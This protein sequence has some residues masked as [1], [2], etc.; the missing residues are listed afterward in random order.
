MRKI[1]VLLA[2]SSLVAVGCQSEAE[3]AG[4]ATGT[5]T[6]ALSEDDLAKIEAH[7]DWYVQAVNNANWDLVASLYTE[8][9]V[10]MPPDSPE[11]VGRDN[12]FA[13]FETAPP[14]KQYAFEIVEMEGSGDFAYVRARMTMTLSIEGVGEVEVVGKVL[15]ILR[16][17]ADGSWRISH[18]ISNFDTPLPTE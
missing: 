11:I 14:I 8:D 10:L 9:A 2:L 17:L 13:L 5:A 7:S 16:R 18:Q 3:D 1:F 12:I 15:E 4:S 6:A